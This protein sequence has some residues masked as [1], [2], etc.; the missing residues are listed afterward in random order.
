MKLDSLKLM[1][2]PYCGS[3]LSLGE[4]YRENNMD[5]IDGFVLCGCNKYPIL[6]GILFL[7]AGHKNNKIKILMV[8]G[9]IRQAVKVAMD[10][11]EERFW[12]LDH[13]LRLNGIYGQFFGDL[14]SIIV[15]TRAN[16]NYKKYSDD[17]IPFCSMLGN[18]PFDI[19]LKNRFSADSFWSLYP[20]IP[21]IKERRERILDLSCGMGHSSFL[22]STY[23]RP[24]ELIC[25]DYSFRN[26]YLAKKYFVEDAALVCLD[27]NHSL[28]FKDGIFSS[29]IM[30]DAFHYIKGQSSLAREMERVISLPGLLLL[31][32]LHNKL[33]ENLAAGQPLT[34]DGW[35]NLFQNVPF[36]LLPEKSVVEDFIYRNKINLVKDYSK[37]DLNSSDALVIIGGGNNSNLYIHQD[38]WVNILENK[39]N[40]I[41]NPCYTIERKVDSVILSRK[42]P[43]ESFKNEYPL[44]K[45]YLPEECIINGMAAKAITGRNLD[46]N[47]IKFSEYDQLRIEELM[48]KFV[49]INVP[50]NYI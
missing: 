20:F 33:K 34:P 13:F 2:C 27:A 45:K 6:D 5:I 17:N 21:L 37:D 22:L 19:Y 31:L 1:K 39:N 30:L 46:I 11:S 40:L 43:S 7:K 36:K 38:V 25:A 24:K 47:S 50:K 12:E 10:K 15:K 14:L 42:Y 32:H 29:I 3:D 26:L 16:L 48:R 49:I 9:K 35:I 18:N 8:E 41:I 4:V 28:P 23:V 44:M